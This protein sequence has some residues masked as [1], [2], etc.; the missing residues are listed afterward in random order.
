V[1]KSLEGGGIPAGF[2][3]WKPVAP[4]RRFG[5][6]DEKLVFL[7]NSSEYLNVMRARA[8][9]TAYSCARGVKLCRANPM[10]GSG[11]K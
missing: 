4:A 8:L 11:M 2:L 3:I 7:E 10:S 6:R 9:E 5:I 1:D